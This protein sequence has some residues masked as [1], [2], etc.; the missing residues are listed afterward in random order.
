VQYLQKEWII[1]YLNAANNFQ[2]VHT[3]I[4][5]MVL[6]QT[7]IQ[8]TPLQ[9]VKLENDTDDVKI[10]EVD[11]LKILETV[12]SIHKFQKRSS[13]ISFSVPKIC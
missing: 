12:Y 2:R 5:E 1:H 4:K 6:I 13:H 7:K 11:R 3:D 8:R 10:E 9:R